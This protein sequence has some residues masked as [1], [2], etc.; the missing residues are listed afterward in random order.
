MARREPPFS[1]RWAGPRSACKQACGVTA[2]G[3]PRRGSRRA[4]RGAAAGGYTG[5]SRRHAHDDPAP[6][7]L[8]ALR[9]RQL[10]SS[11]FV[12]PHGGGEGPV[13]A[14]EECPA[15]VLDARGRQGG[16][17]AGRTTAADRYHPPNSTPPAI[18]RER[19]ATRRN[20]SHT[21]PLTYILRARSGRAGG[22]NG[23][24]VTLAP[25]PDR[26]VCLDRRV[27]GDRQGGRRH[28]RDAGGDALKWGDPACGRWWCTSCG[29]EPTWRA[30]RRET[31]YLR[32][33]GNSLFPGGRSHGRGTRARQALA[34]RMVV[35][36][37]G[38]DPAYSVRGRVI[39]GDP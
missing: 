25:D 33:R 28:R 10:P 24:G 5:P 23:R 15:K 17:L 16:T 34:R 37:A 14:C 11:L 30:F 9:V 4:R 13:R 8:V 31:L 12:A 39:G 27:G 35:D 2:Q 1:R 19:W 22:G 21:L 36:A 29:S 18:P 3:K 38:R 26:A 6:S 7:D 20:L 32:E